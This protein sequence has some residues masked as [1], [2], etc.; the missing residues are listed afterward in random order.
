[1]IFGILQTMMFV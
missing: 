1:M